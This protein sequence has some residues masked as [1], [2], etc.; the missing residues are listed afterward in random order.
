[1]LALL[2]SFSNSLLIAVLHSMRRLEGGSPLN[3]GS[4]A[5]DVYGEDTREHA[6]GAPKKSDVSYVRTTRG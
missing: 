5:R 3:R 4:R 6:D 1:M 2:G